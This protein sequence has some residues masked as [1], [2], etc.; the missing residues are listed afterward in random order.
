M[1]M[2]LGFS[3]RKPWAR[4]LLCAA[5]IYHIAAMVSA[6]LPFNTAFGSQL[7]RPFTH[8]IGYAGLWQNWVMF[9][10]IPHFRSLR[11]LLIARYPGGAQSEHGPML[12]GLMPYEHRT[13]LGSLFFR[14]TWPTNDILP[15][16]RAYLQRACKQVAR[17]TGVKPSTMTMRLDSRRLQSLAD[18]RKT[19]KTSKPASDFST[20][21]VPCD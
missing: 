2:M 17:A 15:Y 16:G 12:P 13:R 14:Y 1:E 21:N 6:N 7:R 8:Y 20:M 5:C 3:P 9:H 4:A 10:T 11:P 18:A 19:G